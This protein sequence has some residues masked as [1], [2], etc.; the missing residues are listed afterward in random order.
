ML[1]VRGNEQDEAL[2]E[3][4]KATTLE[5]GNARFAYV[6]AVALNSLGRIE[7]SVVVMQDAA[8]RFPGDFDIQW[9]LVALLRDQ[10]R[11]DEAK[12][13]AASLAEQFPEIESV[14]VLQHSL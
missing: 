11:I 14:Q 3:L 13:A 5:P 6:Y 9:A 10:G 2:L 1:L 4:D 7:R 8:I 12:A